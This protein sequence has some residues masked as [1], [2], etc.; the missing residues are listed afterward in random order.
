[1]RYITKK[2]IGEIKWNSKNTQLIWKKGDKK[3]KGTI[4]GLLE[5]K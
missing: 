5:T 4:T 1:M 3:K 2:S